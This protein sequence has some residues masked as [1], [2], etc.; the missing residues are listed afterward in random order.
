M[1]C[2][3]CRAQC[4]ES[5]DA[6][7]HCGASLVHSVGTQMF[8]SQ[9]VAV[10]AQVGSAA[11]VTA[12][13]ASGVQQ[14]AYVVA[15]G[16]LGQEFGS[17]RLLE[18]LGEGGMGRVYLAEH[19]KIG[20]KVALKML[21]SHLSSQREVIK[22]FF[23]EARAVN[24]ILHE[25]IVEI[26][27]FIEN[28][29]GDN[30]FI[31]EYLR[32]QPLSEAIDVEG[33]ISLSRSI[34]I[35]VQVC[36]ALAAVHKAGIVHRDL[37]PENI[38]LTERG[39]Q[40][41]FVKL[42]DFGI[43][44][45]MDVNAGVSLQ[46]TAAGVIMGTPEYMSPQQANG[47][48]VDYRTDIYS[49]GVILYELVTGK[50]PFEAETFGALCRLHTTEPPV[51]PSKVPGLF[52]KVPK[53]LEDLILKCLEKEPEDRPQSVEEIEEELRLIAS[54]YTVELEH[55]D[56][57]PGFG[58]NSKK[59]GAMVGVAVL[60]AA[61]MF[62]T[63]SMVTGGDEEPAEAQSVATMAPAQPEAPPSTAPKPP[64]Q[65]DVSFVSEPAG[66]LVFDA[67]TNRALG[68]TPFKA[69]MP[70]SD[71]PAAVVFRLS[72]YESIEQIVALE[73][74]SEVRVELVAKTAAVKAPP[75]R[76]PVK[77]KTA[78]EANTKTTKKAATKKAATKKTK[79][80]EGAVMDPFAN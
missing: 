28:V 45:L 48:P 20:R 3:S 76:R 73:E 70:R 77:K 9:Q 36:S 34:G 80:R 64:E 17:Y 56:V 23:A 39:G 63:L 69:P 42:L 78:E 19:T 33:T 67:K 10:G 2:P 52:Q 38:F 16:M 65:V 68:T 7:A 59:I 43:A 22:R 62:V 4:D 8:G 53:P 12:D 32:G 24:K 15:D 54:R 21:H 25:H 35:A 37:K 55:Y 49:L 1:E 18:V 72:G 66:A 40:K 41:D 14:T 11:T 71:E 5:L 29:D 60:A 44:K 27:D 30:Y 74:A 31:M 61:I 46:S 26:T 13:T 57:S 47:Q 51:P 75:V 6:C 50:K 58:R 79:Y